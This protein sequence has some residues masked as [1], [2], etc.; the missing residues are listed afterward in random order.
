MGYL[1]LA[2]VY[3]I[4]CGAY[5][6]YLA[7]TKG[8]DSLAWFIGGLFLGIFALIAAAGLPINKGSM[9]RG[10]KTCPDCAEPIKLAANTCKYCGH[11]F[12]TQEIEILGKSNDESHRSGWT[13]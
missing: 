6:A 3:G 11:K 7:K 12:S 2:I 13:W 9:D 1:F 5:C 8:Y 4:I 10:I